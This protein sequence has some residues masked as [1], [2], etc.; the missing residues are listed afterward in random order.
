MPISFPLFQEH[1]HKIENVGLLFIQTLSV[2]VNVA[3]HLVSNRGIEFLATVLST[4]VWFSS[5]PGTHYFFDDSF[6]STEANT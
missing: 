1:T 4:K 5:V 2:L 6:C 3:Y